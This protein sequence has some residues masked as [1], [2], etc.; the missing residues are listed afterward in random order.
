MFSFTYDQNKLLYPSQE[1]PF[2][3]VETSYVGDLEWTLPFYKSVPVWFPYRNLVTVS[4][5]RPNLLPRC[6]VSKKK[7][8]VLFQ[9]YY[10][11]C[12]NSPLVVSSSTRVSDFSLS[13][14]G[15]LMCLGNLK[16]ATVVFNP[17]ITNPFSCLVS[18]T[19]HKL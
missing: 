13:S 12:Y 17:R 4:T 19:F 9:H 8:K 10:V 2:D 16:F 5:F 1:V 3:Y 6:I 15:L 18:T 14:T 7:K 11:S